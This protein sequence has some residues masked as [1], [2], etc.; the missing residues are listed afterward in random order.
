MTVE[1]TRFCQ[2][3]DY[4]MNYNYNEVDQSLRVD[5]GNGTT[6][7]EAYEGLRAEI[8]SL[9]NEENRIGEKKTK[10][11]ELGENKLCSG[12]SGGGSTPKP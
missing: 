5:I 7:E 1:N 2:K 11:P 10:K 8:V 6:T 4:A 12:S 3:P 9:E